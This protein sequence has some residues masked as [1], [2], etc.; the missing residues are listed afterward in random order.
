MDNKDFLKLFCV[1]PE[2]FAQ[3]HALRKVV[4]PHLDEV[5]EQVYV[6]L[7]DVL[8][9]DFDMHF[10]DEKALTRAKSLSRRA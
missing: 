2:H 5:I 6:Y 1:T 9:P 4:E 3:I 7:R 10:P 8:G